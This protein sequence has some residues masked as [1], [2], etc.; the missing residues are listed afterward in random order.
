VSPRSAAALLFC[1]AGCSPSDPPP[2]VP[3]DTGIPLNVT[4]PEEALASHARA[5]N[6]RDAGAYAALLE[7]PA[8]GREEAGFRFYPRTDELT[9]FPWMN[10]TSW[11]YDEETVM[12]RNMMDPNYSGTE[13]PVASIEMTYAV[14]RDEVV[15]DG[16]L[17]RVDADITVLVA[18]DIGWLADTRFLFLFVRDENGHYRIRS[19]REIQVLEPYALAVDRGW[20]SVKN[21]YR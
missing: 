2:V 20:G 8:P 12:I 6:E 18:S 5:L 16:R 19:L 7:R 15:E 13:R 17:L 4:T 1:V 14:T 3:Q 10:G 9:Y 11:G 21:L